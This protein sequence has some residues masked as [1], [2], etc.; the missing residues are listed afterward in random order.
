LRPRLFLPKVLQGHPAEKERKR[1]LLGGYSEKASLNQDKI[2]PRAIKDFREIE[3]GGGGC[4][5]EEW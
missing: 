5:I 4:M 3:K 2:F 1:T